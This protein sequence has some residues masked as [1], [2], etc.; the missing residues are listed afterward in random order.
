MRKNAARIG[1]A[2]NEAARIAIDRS[3][4]AATADLD[5]WSWCFTRGQGLNWRPPDLPAVQADPQKLLTLDRVFFERDVF[6]IEGCARWA[7]WA[8]EPWH[9]ATSALECARSTRKVA[10][11]FALND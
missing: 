6:R 2:C 7:K 11:L 4:S 3:L 5:R 9:R 8:E 1:G 10:R